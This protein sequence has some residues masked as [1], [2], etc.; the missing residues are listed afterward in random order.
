VNKPSLGKGADGNIGGKASLVAVA[1][2]ARSYN[3]LVGPG[4][5]LECG[6]RLEPLLHRKQVVIITDDNVAQLHLR[7]LIDGL[8]TQGIDSETITL[9][10]GEQTKNFSALEKVVDKL[11][12]LKVERNDLIIALGGGVIGDLTG[13]AAA[14]LRRGIDFIQI[15]TTLL[16]QV[17]SSVGGKTGINSRHGKNLVG[18]FHQPRLVLADTLTLETLP[19]RELLAGYAEIVKY[20][21]IRDA[22]FFTWLEEHG[23]ALVAGDERARR[24]AIV[25]SCMYKAEIV[26][27]DETEQGER[28]LLNLGHTF[29]HALEAATDYSARLLHGEGVAIGLAMAFAFS[30]ELGLCSADDARRVKT[31]LA[32]AG[33]P[34]RP[35]DIKGATPDAAEL[36]M[37]IRQDKKVVDGR[38]RFVLVRGIGKAFIKDDVPESALVDFLSR[39]GS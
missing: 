39:Y 12:S 2:G 15:P 29:G 13:F 22:K 35:Q 24:H 38:A 27:A 10:A 1:L 9:E 6:A 8:N 4:L 36:A 37:H 5:L 34:T 32:R 16:A 21:L 18:A 7:T 3:I 14:I 11:L 26:A 25:T 33:L 28:A 19:S 20:A 30:A 31:H 17:D 23:K